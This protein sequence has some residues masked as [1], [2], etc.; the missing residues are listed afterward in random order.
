MSIIKGQVNQGIQCLCKYYATLKKE[1]T[2]KSK[3]ALCVLTW[4]GFQC[5]WLSDKSKV[6]NSM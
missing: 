1:K 2:K 3:E 4:K 6:Q 5:M